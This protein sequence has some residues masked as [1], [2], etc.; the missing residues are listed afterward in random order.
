MQLQCI[1]DVGLVAMLQIV[2][3]IFLEVLSNT[4]TPGR[5]NTWFINWKAPRL[6]YL[7]AFAFRTMV[8]N[9]MSTLWKLSFSLEKN[10]PWPSLYY[11]TFVQAYRIGSHK[12]RNL[13]LLPEFRGIEHMIDSWLQNLWFHVNCQRYE[14]ARRSLLYTAFVYFNLVDVSTD[15]LPSKSPNNHGS[16]E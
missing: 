2:Q 3:H 8:I 1:R 13:R 15:G 16:Y 6:S 4:L 12:A 5:E 14:R 7:I 9:Y 10:A 11:K